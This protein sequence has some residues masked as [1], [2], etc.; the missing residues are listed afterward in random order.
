MLHIAAA[1]GLKIFV[2]VLLQRGVE[3]AV[4]DEG[5]LTA[6]D[7]VRGRNNQKMYQ[8]LVEADVSV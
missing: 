8:Y 6:L 5:G 1:R 4:R 7:Y 3:Q 2:S